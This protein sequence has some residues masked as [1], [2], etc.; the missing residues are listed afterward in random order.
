ME[1][2]N[3]KMR[4]M[5]VTMRFIQKHALHLAAG[6]TINWLRAKETLLSLNPERLTLICQ[7]VA[8]ES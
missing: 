3:Y 6:F 7:P 2:G 1:L 5:G 4:E 8:H